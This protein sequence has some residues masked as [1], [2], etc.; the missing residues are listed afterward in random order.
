MK[1]IIL[2]ILLTTILQTTQAS[3]ECTTTEVMNIKNQTSSS[4]SEKQ[5]QFK[6]FSRQCRQYKRVASAALADLYFS[7]QN[8]P[9][10]KKYFKKAFQ[11]QAGVNPI[12]N[13]EM[14]AKYALTLQHLNIQHLKSRNI[15]LELR[16]KYSNTLPKNINAL[17]ADYIINQSRQTTSQDLILA[18]LSSTKSYRNLVICPS[19][20]VTINFAYNS[21]EINAN[22]RTQIQAIRD[23][24]MDTKLASLGYQYELIGHTDKRGDASYNQRLSEK[25]AQAVKTALI[26]LEPTLASRLSA[27]GKGETELELQ[28]NTEEIHQVNRRVQIR[29]AC[30]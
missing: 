18:A 29:V 19:I 5:Q 12:N 8:Y 24:L 16:D 10:A 2:F 27:Q 30:D 15:F 28:G 23:A 9:Y 4:L 25:R 17:Y 13:D 22:S 1:K 3:T 14:Q 20:N 11:T 26:K 7:Q 21:D 6:M